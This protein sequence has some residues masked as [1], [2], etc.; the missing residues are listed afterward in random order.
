[1]T[2][3]PKTLCFIADARSPH[4]LKWLEGCRPLGWRMAVISHWPGEIPGVEVIVHPL[5]LNGF[6]RYAFAVRRIIRKLEP[7]IVHA[8]QF[9]AH[10]L[11]AW[12]SGCKRM[13]V[14]AWG[15]DI[16]VKP[17][18]SQLVNRLIRFLIPRIDKI[19]TDSNQVTE[20]L[21]RMGA[22]PEQIIN[23]PFGIQR[24][25]WRDLQSNR[26][27][28]SP[29][30]LCS[31][32]LHEPI[33]NIRLILEAF[34]RITADYPQVE[35]WVLGDG[36]LTGELRQ[37][38]QEAHLERVVF[39]GRVSPAEALKKIAMSAVLISIPQSDATPVSMLEAM[40]AGSFPVVS[41][42]PV[43]HDWIRDGENGL[44]VGLNLDELAEALKRSIEDAGL[45]EQ[46][47][48]VNREL[49]KDKA[50]WEEQFERMLEYYRG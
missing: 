14:S 21:L 49:I 19:T 37:Y 28:E 34:A 22:K 36:S 13:V 50:I 1:V 46:A 35:L 8:H 29:M 3:A 41:D 10:A 43:Y 33:Y 31:P 16:L 23:F 11:Y 2:T 20:E 39:W 44:I 26:P 38:A 12:F 45:R 48:R 6:W 32:R 18:Q 27:Q 25:I 4:T 40:A 7:D 42:L 24:N 15:S 17:K 5:P 47:G 9:G 30:V